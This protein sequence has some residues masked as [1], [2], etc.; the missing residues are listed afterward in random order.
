MPLV[1]LL[2]LGQL[3]TLAAGLQFLRV[4]SFTSGTYTYT[5]PSGVVSISVELCG[6]KGATRNG[7]SG[8]YGGRILATH[9]VNAGT[10]FITVVAGSAS[11]RVGGS[12][13]GGNGG[14]KYGGGG[15]GISYMTVSGATFFAAGGGGGA[16]YWDGGCCTSNCGSAGGNGGYPSGSSGVKSYCYNDY[17]GASGGSQTGAGCGTQGCG[18]YFA[19]GMAA[20]A[21]A[22]A[23]G[24]MAAAGRMAAAAAA[25]GRATIYRPPRLFRPARAVA[26][27]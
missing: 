11:G 26:R 13:G 21:V 5:V 23:Q 27:S 7:H 20:T 22:V 9:A 25:A 4:T 1:A 19:G 2:L 14:S 3:C 17:N 10:N 12:P 18:S 8:G 15:G 24:T 6:G 16:Y